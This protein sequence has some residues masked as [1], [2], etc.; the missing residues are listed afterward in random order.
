MQQKAQERLKSQENIDATF[1]IVAWIH[2]IWS[3]N[4]PRNMVIVMG[5]GPVE[6]KYGPIGW[7]GLKTEGVAKQLYGCYA[8]KER[9]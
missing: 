1:I 3:S 9:L 6:A 8:Y 7:K 5:K 4:N 2:V